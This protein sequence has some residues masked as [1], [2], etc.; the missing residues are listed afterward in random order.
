EG[1][2]NLHS[3]VQNNPIGLIDLWGLDDDDGDLTKVPGVDGK[4]CPTP[5][6]GGREGLFGDLKQETHQFINETG[7]EMAKN[8]ACSAARWG[9]G[10]ALGAIGKKGGGVEKEGKGFFKKKP[11]I[12]A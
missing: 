10:K 11:K 9:V 8:A 3:F 1:G 4:D 12:L 6:S 5:L 7:K 2:I